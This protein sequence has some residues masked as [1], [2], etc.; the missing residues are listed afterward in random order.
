MPRRT[1]SST[2]APHAVGGAATRQSTRA[3]RRYHGGDRITFFLV[4][5]NASEIVAVSIFVNGSSV[6]EW[7]DAMARQEVLAAIEPLRR[8]PLSLQEFRFDTLHLVGQ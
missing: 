2:V 8:E 3:A 1:A 4:D 5:E 6:Q 7:Q